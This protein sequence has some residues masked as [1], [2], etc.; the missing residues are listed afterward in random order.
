MILNQIFS[1]RHPRGYVATAAGFLLLV[2]LSCPGMWAQPSHPFVRLSSPGMWAQLSRPASPPVK[3]SAPAA[4]APVQP[5]GTAHEMTAADLEAFLDG[6]MPAQLEREDIAGAVIAVVKDGQV[7]FAKGYGYSDMAKRTPVTPDSTLFRPGSISKLFT[8]TSVMQLVEQG[9]LDLDRDVNDYLDFKIPPAYGKP[10]TLRNLL[11]HTPGFEDTWNDMFVRDA[12]HMYPLGQYLKTHI[13]VRIFPPGSVPAYSN[14]GA[15]IAG[16][17]VQRVS[18]K[19]F[20]QYAAENI[21]LPLGMKQTTFV[22]PL[23]E[24]LK[25]LMSKGYKLASSDPKPFEFSEAFPAGSISTTALDMCNFMIAHLQNGKFGSSQILRP[26]TA[27]LMHSRLFGTDDRLNGFAHGF[28]EESANGHRIIGHGGDTQYFHSDLHLILDSNVGFFVSYNSKGKGELDPRSVLFKKFLDRYFPYTQPPADKMDTAK[29]DATSIVGFY[30]GSRRW[31][32]SFLK[33]VSLFPVGLGQAKVL[34]NSDGT[35]SID[36]FEGPNGQLLKFEEVDPLFY[37]EVNGRS[38]L[39]FKRDGDGQ[40]QFQSNEP[41]AIFQKVGFWEN[42]DFNFANLIL[43]LGVMILTVVLWPVG[44]LVR[45]H[46]GRPLDLSPLDRKLRLGVRLVC[47]LFIIFFLGW[48]GVFVWCLGDFITLMTAAGPWILCFGILGV[49]CVLGT[50]LVCVNAFRSWKT[51]GRWI[52]AKLHDTALAL[53]CVGLTLFS[54]TWKLMN[55]NLHY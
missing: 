54:L 25:P 19:P 14:Y 4:V 17:I 44:A 30:Q 8:W 48:A 34:A 10:I 37:R 52:W 3:P 20:E 24:E 21:F 36:S 33:V 50:I 38:H 18:G 31:E 26:E 46:Y 28:Y 55:F 53:S 49:M 47:L 9:K 45:K 35:I 29:A 1:D 32:N 39:A 7:I 5:P 22:Q 13:P 11:T 12:Q 2:T 6:L 43:S 51:T 15:A 42:K 41:D 23:P 40:M 27:T 16:Y